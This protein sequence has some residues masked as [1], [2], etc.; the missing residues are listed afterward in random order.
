MLATPDHFGPRVFQTSAIAPQR[1]F[2]AWREVVTGWLLDA[3]MRPATDDPFQGRAC[4][5]VLPEMRYGWGALGGAISRRTR[6]IV[7]RDNDDLFLFVNS[8]GTFA[9]SQ[10]GRQIEIA[11]G[12]AYLMS[13]SD[14]GAFSWPG[15]MKLMAVRT[16][17]KGVAELVRNVYDCVGRSLAPDNDGLRLL[18]RYL[19][20]LH[21][22]EPLSTPEAQ[23]LVTRHVQD[24]IALALGASGDSQ[25]IAAARGL[26]AARLKAMEA[27]IERHLDNPELA[28]DAVARHL[29]ISPRT[30]Q[31][32]FETEGT[33]FS[34]FVLKRRL[35]RA[36]AVLGDLRGNPARVA[37]VA[38]ACGFGNVSYFNRAFRERYGAT[39]T[40]IRNR[41]VLE[42]R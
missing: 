11:G 22:A 5:R 9:A 19:R 20:A 15:G 2:A 4:L 25:E 26:R 32:L 42:N 6:S 35:A 34:G 38:L 40:D 29:R 14:V 21:G 1:R 24:L 7:S 33:T 30:V 16:R 10:C 13:C 17:H 27:L 28:P 39:P 12:G 36:L 31:R 41:D 8:G 37:D 23:T 3:E 18:I